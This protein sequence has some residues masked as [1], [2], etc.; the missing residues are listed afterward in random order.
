M[1]RIISCAAAG[2]CLIFAASW[3][4][5][6]GTEKAA[7]R[8]PAEAKAREEVLEALQAEARGDNER[9]TSLLQ[10]AWLA[11][12]S[13]P[14]ANWQMARV[15]VE[16][17]WKPVGEAASLAASD[18]NLAKYRENRDH[19]AGNAKMLREVAR[20]C[21]K[22]G[23]PDLAR[24]HYA[25]LLA[26]PTAT[27]EMRMEAI[28]EL[29]LRQVD[30][31]WITKEEFDAR[32]ST[33]KAIETALER[34]RPKVKALQLAIDG[35]DF[36]RRDKAITELG[37]LND[38]ALI[39]VLESFLEDG[40]P[41]FHEEAV[42]RLAT[43]PQYE[44][45]V[46]LVRYAVLSGAP[47]A[48]TAA[49][50]ALQ[51]RPM[52]E[53]VPLLLGGLTAPIKSQFQI[54]WDRQGRVSYTHAF[55]RQGTTGNLLL[56]SHGLS[57]P[58]QQASRSV[59][60]NDTVRVYAPEKPKETKTTT[61]VGISP[62]AALAQQRDAALA[63]A[64]NAEAEARV[65]NLAVDQS[66]E[67]LFTT[68]EQTTNEQLPR[69]PVQWWNWWQGYN[70]YQWPRPTV[71]CYQS[72]AQAY[73]SG[74]TTYT[75]ITGT[76]G[77]S[78]F[79]AGTPI[80]SQ[81]GLVPIESIKPG[82]RV[83]AQDQNTG[84]LAHAVV[85]TTTLRPPAKMVRIVT[86]GDELVTTLGH[87][88]WVD[89]HGWKMAKELATGDL[90]HSLGGAVRIDKVEP[91]G[92]E[93]AYNLVVDDFNTYFVGNAGLLV[94]DNEFR[95]PTRAVVPGLIEDVAASAKK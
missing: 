72:S 59:T 63:K 37:K 65:F 45:T 74:V 56:V 61:V 35:V 64:A 62:Q 66:N 89:G 60:Q 81:T 10:S 95:K 29:D 8:D 31:A 19:A 36:N 90:L 76:R 51:K 83:L 43:F 33:L 84:E 14:E 48:R 47:L 91:A 92:Q 17:E 46:A 4:P 75:H 58:N 12:P 50:G 52:H 3:F 41:Q 94:H 6:F 57:V 26:Q 5:A 25:Q 28:K 70:E 88:F 44:A 77:Y 30:G 49:I 42:K 87:P 7:K 82:D 22:K 40:G 20:W 79:R 18:P 32:A 85:L 15:R 27:E 67:R 2:S 1:S 69:E 93:Q 71:Y 11:A 86:G 39:A 38:P 80:R 73:Q 24:L 68:L 55:L 9:R 54:S 16:G 53:Y 13:L 78:C 23:W 34:W 21:R